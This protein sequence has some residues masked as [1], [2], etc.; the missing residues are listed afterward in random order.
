M[1]TIEK[2]L[3]RKIQPDEFTERVIRMILAIPRGKVATYGQIAELAG[4]PKNSRQ[5]GFILR[6]MIVTDLVPWQRVVGSQGKIAFPKRNKNYRLQRKFLENERV[7]FSGESI[8][9]DR[10]RWRRRPTISQ[11]RR[12]PRMF[13]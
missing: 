4:K 12:A 2:Y 3:K 13:A 5:V 8:N 1:K 6:T 11:G 7:V 10:F 9:L